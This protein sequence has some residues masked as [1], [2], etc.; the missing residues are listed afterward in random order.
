M[1]K[2]LSFIF[3]T[4]LVLSLVACGGDTS[5]AKNTP[6]GGEENNVV[7][8]STTSSYIGTWE[9]AHMRFTVNKGGIGRYDTYGI[10][11]V[12]YYDFTYEVKDEVLVITMNRATGEYIASFELNDDGTALT[13]LQDG[14]PVRMSGEIEFIKQKSSNSGEIA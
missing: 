5:N 2:S 3:L 8:K 14:L 13:I 12:G 7:D 10:N 11:N 1:R 9:S 4:V 6:N